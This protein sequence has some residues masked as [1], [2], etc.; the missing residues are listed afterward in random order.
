MPSGLQGASSLL[1][2]VVD[3]ALTVG[4]DFERGPAAGPTLPA[5]CSGRPLVRRGP[6]GLLSTG[7]VRTRLY[8]RVPGCRRLCAKSSK[9]EFG[10]QE[11]GFLGHRLFAAG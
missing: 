2:R 4:L 3:Q 9:C 10:R 8:G 11:L 5:P 6:G 1:A 7:P